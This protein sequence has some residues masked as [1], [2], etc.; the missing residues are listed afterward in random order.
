MSQGIVKTSHTP[1]MPLQH[2][3]VASYVVL[4]IPAMYSTVPADCQCK[5][6]SLVKKDVCQLS[7]GAPLHT[8]ALTCCVLPSS[9]LAVPATLYL[10]SHTKQWQNG[11]ELPS[12]VMNMIISIAKNKKHKYEIKLT[13]ISLLYVVWTLQSWC[14][15]TSMFRILTFHNQPLQSHC[16]ASLWLAPTAWP[17]RPAT[18]SR[19][20]YFVL[21]LQ[22]KHS[23]QVLG[24]DACLA[25]TLFLHKP[26]FLLLVVLQELEEVACILQ[27]DSPSLTALNK[28][29]TQVK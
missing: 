20:T 4:P 23:T 15:W 21:L 11:D 22:A 18:H 12:H 2:L 24:R 9:H 29:G 6:L 1:G 28:A 3:P 17:C 27:P 26:G 13:R 5:T 19:W 14:S 25:D 10:L 7:A 16:F 8:A